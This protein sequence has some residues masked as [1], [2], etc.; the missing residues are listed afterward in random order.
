LR[1]VH[2]LSTGPDYDVVEELVLDIADGLGALGEAIEA[3]D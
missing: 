1:A 3:A 2:A